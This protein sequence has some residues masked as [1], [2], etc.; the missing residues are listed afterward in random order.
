M[1]KRLY[2]ELMVEL[3]HKDT[4]V[5]YYF[6]CYK[7][8]VIFSLYKSILTIC[9][10]FTENMLTCVW[11][12]RIYN[13]N[14]YNVEGDNR[15]SPGLIPLTTGSWQKEE[16]GENYKCFITYKIIMNSLAKNMREMLLQLTRGN[17]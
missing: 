9:G 16:K 2:F 12:I 3:S 14:I 7:T 5:H 1:D 11:Q 13:P 8:F 6:V 10:C 4:W 17:N 15:L